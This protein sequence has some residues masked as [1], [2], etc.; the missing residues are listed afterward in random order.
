[1]KALLIVLGGLFLLLQYSLWFGEGS[2][3]NAWRLDRQITAQQVANQILAERNQSLEA[4]VADL[5]GGLDA[6]EERARSELGMIGKNETFFQV[7]EE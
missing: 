2:L 6:V 1:M 3:P 4:E 7:V 5:K